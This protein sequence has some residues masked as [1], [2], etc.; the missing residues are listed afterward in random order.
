MSKNLPAVES[1]SS[2]N[3]IHPLLKAIRQFFTPPVFSEDE[4]KTRTA[5]ILYALL[6]NMLV[7]L[8]LAM[9]GGIFI[10]VNKIGSFIFVLLILAWV[11]ISRALVQRGR[12]LAASRLFVAFRLLLT[13]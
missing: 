4:D 3:S 9:L 11:L 12:V 13:V 7:V 6:F 2:R 5:Q 10:F 8:L 1:E